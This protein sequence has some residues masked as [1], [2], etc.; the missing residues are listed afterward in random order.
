MCYNDLTAVG[1]ISAAHEA[2]VRV[3]EDLSVVGYDNIPLSAFTVPPLTTID[4]PEEALGR[5]AVENCV[6]ALSG[7]KVTDVVL[8]S[9]L[10]IRKSTSRHHPEEPGWQASHTDHAA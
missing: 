10:V 3:P 4:Q 9:A 2:G 8:P 5:I 7:E 6:R 1:L